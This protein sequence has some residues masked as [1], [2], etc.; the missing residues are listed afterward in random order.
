MNSDRRLLG[1]ARLS[2]VYIL[3]L[4][5]TSVRIRLHSRK[6]R[7]HTT[8]GITIITRKNSYVLEVLSGAKR[9]WLYR[10]GTIL[11]HPEKAEYASKLL[12]TYSP[13]APSGLLA[14]EK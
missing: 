10:V 6:G 8:K 9:K 7:Q 5:P 12:L 4:E 2:L 13:A 1:I 14:S 3:R 11:Q